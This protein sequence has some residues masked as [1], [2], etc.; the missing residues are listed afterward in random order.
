MAILASH[1]ASN[2]RIYGPMYI[3]DVELEQSPNRGS[4]DACDQCRH[5]AFS[6]SRRPATSHLGFSSGWQLCAREGIR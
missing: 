2:T 4:R 5:W 6:E 3:S 1:F